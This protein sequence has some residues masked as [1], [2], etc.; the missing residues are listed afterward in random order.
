M[1]HADL[2]PARAVPMFPMNI[3][4]KGPPVPVA[5][6]VESA[7]PAAIPLW[8][9]GAPGSAARKGEPEDISWRQEPDIVFAVISNIHNPSLTPFLPAKDKATGCAVIIA[10]GGG[11]W[12]LTIDREGYDLARWFADRGIAAFVLKYRLARDGSTPKGTPQP[13]KVA[14]EGAAD[15]ARAVRLIRAHAT[16]WG[17]KPD[18]I[19]ILGF[20]AGGEIALHTANH[21]TPGDPAAADPVE[22]VSSKPDFFA[23][24]YSG[25][26]NR[27]EFTW[28]KENTPPAFLSCTATDSMPEQMAAFFSTLHQAGVSAELHIYASGGHGYGVRGDRPN[29]PVST[30][31]VR[32]VE[33]LGERGF[34]QR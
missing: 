23:P 18:R 6:L 9:D 24:I 5:P 1:L 12:Q 8:A 19:G 33:W 28:T 7:H 21:H 16:E 27:P 31:H 15:G 4:P 25:G 29:L 11:H 34:L 2:P 3:D 14:V 26:M 10:P 20:S 32:F 17:I 30:W 22:R 13:Y